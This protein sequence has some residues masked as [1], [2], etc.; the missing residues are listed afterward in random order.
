M[1]AQLLRYKCAKSSSIKGYNC[2]KSDD[3]IRLAVVSLET[4]QQGWSI[5]PGNLPRA[6]F[7]HWQFPRAA[8]RLEQF[9]RPD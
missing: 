8:F 9:P 3:I 4:S 2:S 6:A 1:K 7:R 5:L